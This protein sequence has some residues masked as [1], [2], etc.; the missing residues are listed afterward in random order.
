MTAV[1]VRSQGENLIKRPSLRSQMIEWVLW[2]LRVKTR[3]TKTDGFR[4]RVVNSRPTNP[5]P[6]R[7]FYRRYCVHQTTQAGKLIFTISPRN[8]QARKHLLYLHGG[9]YVYEIMGM[10]WRMLARFLDE[11]DATVTVPLFPLAP[12]YTCEQIFQFVLGVYHV[13]QNDG[14]PIVVIG[15]SSGGGMALSLSQQ[16]R[17]AGATQP[18]KLV[19]VSPWLDVTCS[20][21]AQALLDRS[22]PL[23]AMPGL[24]EAGIWYAGKLSPTDARVSPLYGDLEGLPPILALTGTHDL[25]NSDAHRLQALLAS[26]PEAFKMIEYRNMLHVWPSMP[27]PE[28]REAMNQILTF[29]QIGDLQERPQIVGGEG[30]PPDPAPTKMSG[31]RSATDEAQ[32]KGLDH[33]PAV[34]SRP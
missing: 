31:I 32:V 7:S 9:A 8:G 28:A 17:D 11:A 5:R 26:Q 6:P 23:L 13:L 14:K 4:E 34:V 29:V 18:S 30:N 10:Q 20:D 33:S 27:I 12:E 15:D 22:D 19:L 16:L 24:R 25:L 3:F 1:S 2:R 21:P